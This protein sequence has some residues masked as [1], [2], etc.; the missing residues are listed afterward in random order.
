VKNLFKQRGLKRIV[1]GA[2]SAVVLVGALA[3]CGHGGG[4]RGSESM[5]AENRTKMREKMVERVSS[6]LE[7]TTE[8]KAKLGTLA[9]AVQAQRAGLMGQADPRAEFA[10]VIAGEKFD[11]TKAQSLINEK[12]AAV[13]KQSP[14]TVTAMAD[15]YDSLNPTQ[16]AKVRQFMQER[17]RGRQ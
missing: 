10:S 1:V 4:H 11:R 13:A 3:A 17:K 8:Q 6:K 15:F 7:L 5:S 14:A 16:Q 12:T 2:L 9:D